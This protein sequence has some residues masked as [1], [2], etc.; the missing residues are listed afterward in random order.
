MTNVQNLVASVLYQDVQIARN[1]SFSE[2]S[3]ENAV[4]EMPEPLPVASELSVIFDHPEGKVQGAAVVTRVRESRASGE[5]GQMHLRWVEFSD[6]GFAT[7]AGWVS[8]PGAA[9][10]R[11]PAP[12]P[13][14][15]AAPEPVVDAA[16]EAVVAAAPEPVVDAVPSRVVDEIESTIPIDP[17]ATSL[18]L[19]AIPDAQSTEDTAAHDGSADGTGEEGASADDD[20]SPSG[21]EEGGDKKKRRRRTK[22]K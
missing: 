2:L 6:A 4:L 11:K 1:L 7:L 21:D 17:G 5:A 20:G 10:P 8:E 9:A 15:A 16:P 12:E 3:M 13:V 14:V 18:D 19:P 22:K